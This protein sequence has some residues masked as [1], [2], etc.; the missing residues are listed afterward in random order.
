MY[1]LRSPCSE[2]APFIEHYWFVT[3]KDAPLDLRVD[4]FVDGRADLVLNFGAPY[5]RQIIGG[6]SVEHARS[7]LDAQRLVPIR[8]VQR[9]LVRIAGVRFRLGGLAPFTKVELRAFTGAT[10]PPSAILGEGAGALEH[11]VGVEHDPSVQAEIFDRFFRAQLV[12]DAAHARFALALE[13]LA[14]CDGNTSVET[15]ADLAGV[16]S[17]Q[18]DRLFA[19]R[20]GIA[21]KTV[22][23]VLRFQRALRS[24]MRDPGR[25]LAEIAA[26]AGYFDQSHFV[27]DFRRMTGGVPR[28]YRGYYPPESPTDFA[29]NVVV[30]LQDGDRRPVRASAHGK[31]LVG[32]R[33]EDGSVAA[34]DPAADVGLHD[35]P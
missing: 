18:I 6:G 35:V 22:G 23:R 10:P 30:F 16:T 26:D 11:A 28:G 27:K 24:L 25:P 20:L 14:A 32:Q 8:I 15:I 31:T 2:L 34:Q 12:L 5:T 29:P 7:N 19:R 13:Q 33:H 21:P 17:R 4:V 9:G 1:Q 3:A